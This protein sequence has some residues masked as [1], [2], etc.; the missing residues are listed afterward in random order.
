MSRR[1]KQ[2]TLGV[3]LFLVRAD[4]WAEVR[5]Q[6]KSP[7]AAKYQVFKQAREAGYYRDPRSGFRDFLARGWV[8][9]DLGRT[10]QL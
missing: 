9:R 2:L 4:G 3:R 1:G 10:I 5:V 7:A 8:A 6:A